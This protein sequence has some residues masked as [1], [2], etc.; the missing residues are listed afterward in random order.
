MQREDAIRL[1][2]MLDT[3]E[4][5]LTFI[6]GRTRED[7]DLDRMLLF[8][9]THALLVIGEAAMKVG[10]ETRSQSPQ[11]EWAKMVSMRHRLVHAYFDVDRDIV[12][13][14]TIEKLA[15]LV[16]ELRA[17]LNSP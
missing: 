11:I 4:T 8:G 3:A 16:R 15:P 6:D 1:Q 12:W 5:A 14:T 13:T 7:L 17:I 10:D 9:L 2:H